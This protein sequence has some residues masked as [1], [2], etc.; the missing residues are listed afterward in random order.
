MIQRG[1]EL[2][3]HTADSR[4][5][6]VLV[7]ANLLPLVGVVF[8]GWSLWTILTVYW[9][10]NGIVGLWNI[11]K[12]LLAEGTFLPDR[13]GVGYSAWATRPMPAMGRVALAVFFTFHYG[14]FWLVHGVF[15][16]VLPT[17]FG[18]GLFGRL[19]TSVGPV[20][21]DP[22]GQLMLFDAGMCTSSWPG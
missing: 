20:P 7:A 16:L 1:F 21:T 10:E 5:A 19:F 18:T 3:R 4:S 22:F 15:V 14:L 9:L 13:T 17:F 2:Y 12:I 6:L 8:F 11:P